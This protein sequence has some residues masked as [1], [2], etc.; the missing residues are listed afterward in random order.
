MQALVEAST[1]LLEQDST[2]FCNL[3][4]KERLVIGDRGLKVPMHLCP[5]P[6]WLVV[7]LK[8]QLCLDRN[9]GLQALLKLSL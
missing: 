2:M 8:G 6:K 4:L 5:K 1:A 9:F 3:K 7:T